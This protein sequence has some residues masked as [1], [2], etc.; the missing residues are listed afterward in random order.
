MVLL[1]SE[2]HTWKNFSENYP[3]FGHKPAL[4]KTEKVERISV[5][6]SAKLLTL[7]RVPTCIG[8]ALA[9][10]IQI[11][12]WWWW[13]IDDD[14]FVQKTYSVIQCSGIKDQIYPDRGSSTLTEVLLPWLRFFYPDWGFSTLTEVLPP[15]LRFFRAFSSVVRQMP[16]Y[17]SPSRG[18]ACTL[19]RNFVL[20]YCLFCVVLCIVCV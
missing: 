7:P 17:N 16:G 14:E 11:V 8:L 2:S 18:T 19:P 15:W 5:L 20:F 1:N 10:K 6:R 4:S 12:F 3:Q 9:V 13:W